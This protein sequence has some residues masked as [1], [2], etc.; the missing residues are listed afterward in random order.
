M[1]SVPAMVAA[2]MSVPA[3]V[4]VH[5]VEHSDLLRRE[6]LPP[7]DL[8]LRLLVHEL[9]LAGVQLFLLR[10]KGCVVRLGIG[11]ELPYLEG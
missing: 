8:H 3:M 10:E 6:D 4:A 5:T 2:V 7:F 11:E 9:G 1:V